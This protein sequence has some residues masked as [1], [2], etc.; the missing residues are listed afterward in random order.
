M[1]KNLREEM[2]TGNLEALSDFVQRYSL[3]ARQGVELMR[4]FKDRTQF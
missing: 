4:F 2:H 3:T 1:L